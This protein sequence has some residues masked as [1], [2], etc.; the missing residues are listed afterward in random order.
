M[1][2]WHTYLI[3]V[4]PRQQLLGQWRELNS[5]FVKQDKHILINFVYD[6]PKDDLYSYALLIISEMNRRGYKVD[7]NNFRVYFGD[8]KYEHNMFPFINKMTGQYLLQCIFNLQEKH[9]CG[10]I[11]DDEW[12]KIDKVA[13]QRVKDWVIN[14]L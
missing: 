1:R 5:I 6:Y 10:G 8:E 2:I 13:R 11:T 14:N 4:L 3:D 12:K 9:D 7:S